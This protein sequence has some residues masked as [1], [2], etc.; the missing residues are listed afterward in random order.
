MPTATISDI[1]T[2]TADA[3]TR[4]NREGNESQ[5][6]PPPC[7]LQ[8]RPPSGPDLRKSGGP[9]GPPLSFLRLR[10]GASVPACIRGTGGP[11]R[12]PPRRPR[13]AAPAARGVSGGVSGVCDA[14]RE[15]R[16][17]N[18]Y[19]WFPGSGIAG[20]PLPPTTKIPAQRQARPGRLQNPTIAYDV[21]WP[22][23]GQ[24]DFDVV[25][26]TVRATVAHTCSDPT[27]TDQAKTM[28]RGM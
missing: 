3:A 27:R 17:Y 7:S 1:P 5:E 13:R 8:P 26:L 16:W 24:R 2:R 4:S 15:G 25:L 12:G 14:P 22:R 23:G 20:R 10:P 28:H 11:R 19:Q 18:L 9:P 6:L 21:Q